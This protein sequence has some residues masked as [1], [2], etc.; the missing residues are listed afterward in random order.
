MTLEIKKI[1]KQ[2]G[3]TQKDLAKMLGISKIGVNLIVNGKTNPSL[4][5]LERIA[6][7]LDV[8]VYEL[9]GE[10][11]KPRT[12]SAI[13]NDNGKAFEVYS[14]SELRAIAATF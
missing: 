14:P 6:N 8:R 4:D 13:I 11:D 3:I 2:K 7:I 12:F 1:L 5:T 9:L 10:N